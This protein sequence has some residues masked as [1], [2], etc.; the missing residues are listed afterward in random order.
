MDPHHTGTGILAA[1]EDRDSASD[2]ILGAEIRVEVD[3]RFAAVDNLQRMD[4]AESPGPKTGRTGVRRSLI[5]ASVERVGRETGGH[6]DYVGAAPAL[7]KS[8][9]IQAL[10]Q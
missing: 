9:R 8:R 3:S 5:P 10:D 6:K 2:A 1:V 7:R 4:P